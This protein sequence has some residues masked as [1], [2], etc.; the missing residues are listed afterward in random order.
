MWP[1]FLTTASY[2]M[3][4][5]ASKILNGFSPFQ[6]VFVHDPPDLTSLQFQLHVGNTKIHYYQEY[7]WLVDY[8]LSGEL[9]KHSN[10]KMGTDNLQK[11]K[12]W[13]II[14]WYIC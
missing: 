12:F 6:L 14:K 9:N 13:G 11:K 7:K 2:A 1:L 5:F 3:N 10:L 8:Y 4:T